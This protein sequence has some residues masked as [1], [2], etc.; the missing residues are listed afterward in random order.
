M[1]ARRGAPAGNKNA[2]KHG[3]YS[4]DFPKTDL[5]DLEAVDIK[6][7]IE[8]ISLLHL[9]LRKLSEQTC[10]VSSPAECLDLLSGLYLFI[11]RL[12]RLVKT[13]ALITKQS[14]ALLDECEKVLA[15]VPAAWPKL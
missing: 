4:R 8:E 2:L 9:H 12:N 6:G 15:E 5:K 13:Q 7:L 1:T 11:P 10:N 3:Y 14:S